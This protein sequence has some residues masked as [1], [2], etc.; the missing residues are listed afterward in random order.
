MAVVLMTGACATA[1]QVDVAAEEQAIRAISSR[2]LELETARDAAGIAGLFA[3]DGAM[4]RP[5][6]EPIVGRAAIEGHLGENFQREPN[7]TSSWSTDRVDVGSGGDLAV[8]R[9]T[10]SSTG[11][12]EGDDRGWYLTLYRKGEGGWAVVADMVV[13]TTPAPAAAEP[14]APA[15]A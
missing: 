11:S 8:E 15:G 6:R 13:S 4:Y 5:G 2:W 10:W 3:E 14:A 12:S 9:G 7:A 1:P